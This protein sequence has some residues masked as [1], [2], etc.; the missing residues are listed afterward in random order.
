M[1]L[2]LN[3]CIYVFINFAINITNTRLLRICSELVHVVVLYMPI[4]QLSPQN[5]IY[6]YFGY[7]SKELKHD[8]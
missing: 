7:V 5:F 8:F 2:V 3:S 4:L 6:A 1:V